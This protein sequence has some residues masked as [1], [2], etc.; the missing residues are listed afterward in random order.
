MTPLL[1][2]LADR[3]LD[4]IRGLSALGF[5]EEFFEVDVH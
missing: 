1:Q 5:L 4:E 2:K 3:Q